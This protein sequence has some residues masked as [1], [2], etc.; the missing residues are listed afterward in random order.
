[1]AGQPIGKSRPGVSGSGGVY[2]NMVRE[3]RAKEEGRI[4]VVDDVR[5]AFEGFQN[6]PKVGHPGEVESL[7]PVWGSGREALADLQE[8]DY[9]GAGLNGV[10]AVSDLIPGKAIAGAA[11]K[12][13]FKRTGSH[14]WNA[15]RKWMGRRGYFEPFEHGHH[16]AIPQNGWGKY[17]PD[18]IKN[19]PMNIKPMS[20]EMHGR[21]H[22]PYAGERQY[23]VAQRYWYGTPTWS[24]A[25]LA[26]GAGH[27]GL[28]QEEASRDPNSKTRPR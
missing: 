7:I 15:T 17:V 3:M 23:N 20:A 26:S 12:G 2:D 24:K 9:L 8:G 16:W 11:A 4:P 6:G 21:I 27:V 13:A 5:E 10:L 1:M 28:Y 19:Q 14:P 18:V 25:A 22:G